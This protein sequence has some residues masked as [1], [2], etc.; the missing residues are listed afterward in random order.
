MRE[1][2]LYV[3]AWMLCYSDVPLPAC[4]NR[5]PGLAQAVRQVAIAA[6]WIGPQE[7]LDMYDGCAGYGCPGKPLAEQINWLRDTRA[8]LLGAPRLAELRSVP[9]GNWVASQVNFAREHV[10]YLKER[11]KHRTA[12]L[13]WWYEDW[14]RDACDLLAFWEQLQMATND[15][16]DMRYLWRRQA[17]RYVVEKI[18]SE[19]LAIGSFPDAVPLWRF[20][21]IP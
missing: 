19:S 13:R 8:T 9:A 20:R 14:Y 11:Q 3:L 18:G 4:I 15:A 5:T 6:E 16:P 21:G 7:R 1:H 12:D 17:L 2:L 10:A